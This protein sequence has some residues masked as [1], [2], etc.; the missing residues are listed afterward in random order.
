VSRICVV[1]FEYTER[2]KARF[3]V[4]EPEHQEAVGK[5]LE[6]LRTNPRACSL[7]LKTV[8]GFPKPTIYKI[9]LYTNHSHQLTFEL[10]GTVAKLLC[11]GT[12]KEID[13][14]PR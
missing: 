7:R 6:L 1:A 10:C 3:K 8:K 13:R 9:D 5:A 2:F 14:S 11:V 4:L 12:H